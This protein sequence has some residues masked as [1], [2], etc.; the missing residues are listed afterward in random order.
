[1][2]ILNFILAGNFYRVRLTNF[3]D[4]LDHLDFFGF[5]KELLSVFER[6]ILPEPNINPEPYLET[7][8]L[9]QMKRVRSLF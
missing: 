5:D 6:I 1:M 7:L 9:K 8:S 4:Y 2:T 3:Y